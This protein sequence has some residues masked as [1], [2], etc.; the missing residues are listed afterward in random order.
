LRPNFSE[1]CLQALFSILKC[2]HWS[3]SES[4]IIV[5]HL[6]LLKDMLSA[7]HLGFGARHLSLT[8]GTICSWCS[9]RLWITG[10]LWTRLR[11]CFARPDLQQGPLTYT[12]N[13][14]SLSA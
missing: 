14:V 6:S 12:V 2:T 5:I 13:T 9:W 8:D 1:S 4:D 7:A 3:S 11:L 10:L